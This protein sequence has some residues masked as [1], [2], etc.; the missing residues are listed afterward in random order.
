M[1]DAS[2]PRE[3]PCP[4]NVNQPNLDCTHDKSRYF[5]PTEF[6]NC[7]IIR[8]P[9]VFLMNILGK[10]SDLPFLRKSVHKKEKT[11]VSF[12]HEQNTC[13]QTQAEHSWT[14]LRM[15]RPLFG[16]SHLQVK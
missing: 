4:P 14:T 12:T 15:S 6:N 8:S 9:R 16:D 3:C 2:R 10:R 5:A 13:S 1:G 11:V 7:F